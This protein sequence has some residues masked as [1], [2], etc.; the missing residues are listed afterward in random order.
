[1]TLL[2]VS[3]LKL[4]LR[5]GE[6][7]GAGKKLGCDP[8]IGILRKRPVSFVARKSATTNISRKEGWGGGGG[9]GKREGKGGTKRSLTIKET[10][11]KQS[12]TQ[13]PKNFVHDKIDI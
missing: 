7:D 1:M 10:K 11:L 13:Q 12:L 4:R 3:Q 5:V 9:G 8:L 2:A 6:E